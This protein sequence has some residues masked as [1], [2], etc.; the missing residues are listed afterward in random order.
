MWQL[1]SLQRPQG[2]LLTGSHCSCRFCCLAL[3]PTGKGRWQSSFLSTPDRQQGGCCHSNNYFFQTGTPSGVDGVGLS[4]IRWVWCYLIFSF[5][6]SQSC[7]AKRAELFPTQSSVSLLF[8]YLG[9]VVSCRPAWDAIINSDV[10]SLLL[11]PLSE[12]WMW[13]C[14]VQLCY[15]ILAALSATWT[16]SVDNTVYNVS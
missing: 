16:A 10:F 2:E 6:P 12:V 4:V 5:L 9:K 1:W 15:W 3:A 8:K 14:A 11:V 7:L 13:R